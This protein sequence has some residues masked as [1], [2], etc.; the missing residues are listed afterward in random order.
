MNETD[1]QDDKL[2]TYKV[3]NYLRNKEIFG[4]NSRFMNVNGAE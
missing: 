2:Y 3:Q 1:I 4:E